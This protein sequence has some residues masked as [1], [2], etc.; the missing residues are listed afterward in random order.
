MKYLVPL[1]ALASPALAN[2]VD[3]VGNVAAKCVIQTTKTGAYGNP[4]PDKLSTAV[5]DG[6]ILPEIR[7]DVAIANSYTANITYPTSFTSSP[8]LSDTVAWTG[9]VAVSNT[10]DAGMSGY[11]SAKTVSGATT[12]YILTTAGST[13]FAVSSTATYASSKPFTGGTYIAQMS[14]SCIPS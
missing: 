4:T 2:N 5:S 11:D 8:S 13:W 14:A 6:G 1:L 7:I 3:I 12:S 10:S 9:S